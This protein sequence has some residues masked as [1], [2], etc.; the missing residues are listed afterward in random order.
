MNYLFRDLELYEDKTLYV[1]GNG[2]DLYHNIPSKYSHFYFWLKMK[3]YDS[4]I[5]DM[6][7]FFLPKQDT[8]S[9]LWMDF[10]RALGEYNTDNVFKRVT[11]GLDI[12]R[13]ENTMRIAEK[14]TKKILDQITPLLKEWVQQI[15]LNNIPKL[16]PLSPKSKYLTFN[17]TLTLENVYKIPPCQ[18]YHIHHC[19]TDDALIVGHN[20]WRNPDDVLDNN[21]SNYYEEESKRKIIEL[22]NGLLKN[23]QTISQNAQCFFDGIKDF[24]RVVVLGHSLS[25]IDSVYFASIKRQV[26]K[27]A[28][29]HFS[30]YSPA[31]QEQIDKRMEGIPRENIWIFNL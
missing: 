7:V 9:L 3:G 5:S 27:D 24:K 12:D 8:E 28:H 1:I 13:D 18:I 15:E 2:F 30:K 19:L 25:D 26:A 6:E 11:E 17:Y 16:L 31:D 22:M 21:Y 29:W 10:E 23:T 14:R 4:L 20:K